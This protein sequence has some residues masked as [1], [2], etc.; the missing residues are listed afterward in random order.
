MFTCDTPT[1]LNL[2]SNIRVNVEPHISNGSRLQL[3]E[4]INTEGEIS[5]LVSHKMQGQ[6]GFV[7]PGDH[8]HYVFGYE[9]TRQFYLPFNHTLSFNINKME[10]NTKFSLVNVDENTKVFGYRSVP[11]V[12]FF[13]IY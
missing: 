7:T 9:K 2:T 8:K 3:P 12:G 13:D 11:Y 10:M 1:V 4:S 6:F 5:L